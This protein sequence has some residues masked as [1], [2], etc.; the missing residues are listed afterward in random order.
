MVDDTQPSPESQVPSMLD[1]ATHTR[2]SFAQGHYLRHPV[3]SLR[4]FPQYRI[5]LIP[6]RVDPDEMSGCVEQKKRL[7]AASGGR[8]RWGQMHE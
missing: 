8:P 1:G 6:C 7:T 2:Q 3:R 5:S 4:A